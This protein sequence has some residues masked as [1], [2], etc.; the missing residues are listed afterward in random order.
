VLER[1]RFLCILS[2]NLD[3]FFETRVAELKERIRLGEGLEIPGEQ[4]PVEIFALLSE[5]A[6]ALVSDQYRLL[7]KEI[8]PALAEE[9]VRFLG[10]G[11]WTREQRAWLLGYF[12]RK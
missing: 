10:E 1:L 4:P 6:H 11:D 5:R 8:F 3:E 2:S 7:N 12:R 9:G